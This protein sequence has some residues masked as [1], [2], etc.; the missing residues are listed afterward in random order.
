M[1]VIYVSIHLYTHMYKIYI[2]FVYAQAHIHICEYV[3]V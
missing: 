3:G 1:H 2:F